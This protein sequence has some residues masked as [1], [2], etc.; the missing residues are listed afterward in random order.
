M[1]QGAVSSLLYHSVS[2][3]G[4]VMS[5]V[6]PRII[7]RV[8]G[9][10]A[11]MSHLVVRAFIMWFDAHI[12]VAAKRILRSELLM[13]T[14]CKDRR[15]AYFVQRFCSDFDKNIHK[16]PKKLVVTLPILRKM[17]NLAAKTI[18]HLSSFIPLS[19]ASNPLQEQQCNKKFS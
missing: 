12:H 7:T 2:P 15:F 5:M 19:H 4:V 18:T 16:S 9:D 14:V 1:V 11:A 6:S 13:F 3:A 10:S 17:C 8:C